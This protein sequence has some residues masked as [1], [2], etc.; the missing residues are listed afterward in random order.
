MRS[1]VKSVLPLASGKEL[2]PGTVCKVFTEDVIFESA[3][4]RTVDQSAFLL[5][6]DMGH[7]KSLHFWTG[8]I[9]QT[10]M[11]VTQVTSSA[12]ATL[13]VNS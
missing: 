3:S 4:T 13:G 2:S 10:S 8:K 11:R 1:N 12:R 6:T 9:K 7:R 5:L